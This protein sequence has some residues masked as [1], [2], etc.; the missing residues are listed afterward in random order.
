MHLLFIGDLNL[1]LHLFAAIFNSFQL[2]F[3]K[4]AIVKLVIH[5]KLQ[6]DRDCL[7]KANLGLL[8]RPGCT[9]LR[10]LLI[11]TRSCDVDV[12]AVTN[13]VSGFCTQIF[14]QFL[15]PCFLYRTHLQQGF[16]ILR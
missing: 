13:P 5:H 1:S 7:S 15:I 10:W 14:N 12:A 9:T 16:L 2:L 6:K 11:I 8:K 4:G 3:S